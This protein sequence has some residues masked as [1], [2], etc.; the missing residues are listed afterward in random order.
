MYQLLL[1]SELQS[2]R[3]SGYLDRCSLPNNLCPHVFAEGF[4][5]DDRAVGLLVVFQDGDEDAGEGEAGAV[6][7]VDELG[8]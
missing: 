8:F 5:D 6:Q 2:I 1:S 7:G 4:G 3:R